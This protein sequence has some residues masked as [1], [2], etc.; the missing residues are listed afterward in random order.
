MTRRTCPGTF[1]V[2]LAFASTANAATVLVNANGI[3]TGATGVNILGALYDVEF[4]DGTCAAVFTGCDET[5]D[6]TFTS[7]A[8]ASAAGQALWDQV[9]LDASAGNFDTHPELTLGCPSD[10]CSALIP[11]DAGALGFLATGPQN[12]QALADLV[13]IV[14]FD[15]APGFDTTAAANLV[16]ARWTPSTAIPEPASLFLLA[17]GLVGLGAWRSRRRKPWRTS[18]IVA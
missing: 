18:S 4:V 12:I 13:S 17:L 16:W 5:S 1:V 15:G 11:V 6:F 2:V 3:L 9:W 8:A 10:Q 14:I 7:L